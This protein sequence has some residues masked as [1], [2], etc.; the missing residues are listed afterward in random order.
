MNTNG[1]RLRH[2]AENAAIRLI[3]PV[4]VPILLG[5]AGYLFLGQVRV[6]GKVDN[7]ATY[8]ST[9][10]AER[11]PHQTELRNRVLELERRVFGGRQ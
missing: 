2:G 1:E 6:E 3:A 10:I 4:G 9:V 5:I 11:T 7:L 8:V